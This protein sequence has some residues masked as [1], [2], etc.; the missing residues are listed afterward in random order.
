MADAQLDRLQAALADRYAVQHELGSGGMAC[1]TPCRSWM[2]ES[3]RQRLEDE[4][5]LPIEHAL[6]IAREVGVCSGRDLVTIL[7]RVLL[8]ST[9]VEVTHARVP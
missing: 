1:T 3:L 2:G 9:T 7:P 8:L 4:K 5:Q 6:K